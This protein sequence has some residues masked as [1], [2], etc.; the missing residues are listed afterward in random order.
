[1]LHHFGRHTS[2][3]GVAKGGQARAGF[4]Q[5]RVGVAVVAAFELDDFFAAGGATRQA[6]GAHPGF[7][8]RADQ[9]HHLDA[10]HELDDF[11]GQFH[12]ALGGRAEAEAVQ[13]GF[14]HGFQHGGVAVAQDHRA[15][16][17][18]EV[19]VFLVVGIPEVSALG[20]L[21]KTR[22]AAHGLEGAHRGVHATGDDLFGAFKELFVAVVGA[23]KQITRESLKK[24]ATSVPRGVQGKVWAHVAVVGGIGLFVIFVRPE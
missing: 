16:R 13:G 8:A 14:L 1:M 6:D 3:G 18:D 10:G 15:P 20:A 9:S 19:D 11:F 4:D 2:A 5:E 21:D 22:R 17:A 12:F 23:H 24:G 7:G